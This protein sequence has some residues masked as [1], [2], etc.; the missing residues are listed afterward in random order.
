MTM[1]PEGR[2][3][4]SREGQRLEGRPEKEA[5]CREARKAFEKLSLERQL[6][7]MVRPEQIEV[8]SDAAWMEINRHLGTQAQSL[9]EL[10]HELGAMRLGHRPSV[11]DPM[12]GGGAIPFE[13]ARLGCDVEGSDLNPVAAL[14][15]WSALHLARL[16]PD[17]HTALARMMHTIANEAHAQ[18]HAWGLDGTVDRRTETAVIRCIQVPRPACG[19]RI[20]VAPS[21]E[22]DTEAAGEAGWCPKGTE[23]VSMH[24]PYRRS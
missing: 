5:E 17:E 8:P 1:D 2:W 14:L 13:A 11:S 12:C 9:P 18:L 20:P 24:G 7:T 6:A 16:D 19:M 23:Q 3:R 21:W 10:M 22:I 4:R 15:S